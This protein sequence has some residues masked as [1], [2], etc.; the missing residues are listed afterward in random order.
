MFY[1]CDLSPHM[2]PYQVLP[3]LQVCLEAKYPA[4]IISW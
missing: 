3:V 1:T 4:T 2:C